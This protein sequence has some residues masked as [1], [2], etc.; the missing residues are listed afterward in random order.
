MKILKAIG[1][2]VLALLALL[3]VPLL[4]P[5]GDVERR[6]VLPASGTPW[7]VDTVEGGFSRVFG[8]DLGR[9]SFGAARDHLGGTPVVALVAA[10]GGAGSLEVFYERFSIGPITGRLVLTLESTLEERDRIVQRAIRVDYMEG[11]TRRI[12]LAPEDLAWA[13]TRTVMAMVFV[14]AVN[15]DE[16]IILQRF[17]P[18]A[19]RIRASE[20]REHF[21]Y[22]ERGLDL[23]L[24]T[25][26]R[27]VLQYVA[28]RDFDRLLRAPLL[29]GQ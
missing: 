13:D 8:V 22:P 3:A 11:G 25:Q 7:Q 26:G 18:P 2:F 28:P 15:L 23:Q 9:A 19:E 1:L 20:H 14:P 17:G 4:L 24:D 6:T 29:K 12:S 16:E 10:T 27:E 5:P 21:L